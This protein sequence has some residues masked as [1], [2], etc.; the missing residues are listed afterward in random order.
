MFQLLARAFGTNNLPD[1]SNMCHES[2]G[3][4]LAETV[5]IGKGSVTLED[6]HQ[7]E[8]ILVVGQNPGTNHPRMLNALKKNKE[9]GG[10]IVSINPLPETGMGKF[11][12]PQS[13]IEILKAEP[14]LQIFICLFRIN[15]DVAVLKGLML[16]MW[17]AEQK[18]SGTVF[19]TKFIEEH[20]DGYPALL[21]DLAA[22]SL[23]DCV[24]ASGISE[25]QLRSVAKLLIEKKNII[26]CWAMGL[27]QHINGVN[28]IRE[29]V[30]LL[31]LKGSIGKPGAGTCPVRGHSNVQGDRTMGIVEKPPKH[32]LKNLPERFGIN[33]PTHHGY[34]VVNAIHAMREG[35]CKVFVAMGRKLH[36]RDTR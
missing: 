17:E 4:G 25:A 31:L 35:K 24:E 1:C 5:G 12:D 20:T 29:V 15:G 32:L 34:D 13:P 36:F 27:T 6:L 16:L 3:T 10:S 18:S 21:A 7:A 22:T 14:V 8:V 30:N 19:D 23:A 33:V 28:N 26:I 2:S 11:V 9:N